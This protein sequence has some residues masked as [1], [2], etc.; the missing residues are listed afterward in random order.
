MTLFA[1]FY[2]CPY[3]QVWKCIGVSTELSICMV[4]SYKQVLMNNNLSSIITKN[5]AK[6][7]LLDVSKNHDLT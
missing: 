4:I 7:G 5:E 2:H 6:L 3:G 1:Y